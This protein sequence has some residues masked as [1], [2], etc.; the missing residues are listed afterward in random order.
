MPERE[1]S[2]Y[3]RLQDWPRDRLEAGLAACTEHHVREAIHKA[4]TGRKLTEDDFL[5]LLSPAAESCLEIMAQVAAAVTLRHFGRTVQLFT[6]LYLANFCTNRCVY[7][8]FNTTNA[9]PRSSLT[10]EDIEREGRAIA[11]TGL[12]HIL[13]L[14]GDARRKTG[15]DYIAAAARILR[16]LFAGIGVEVYSMHEEEYGLLREAGVDSL[17]VF[18]ETYNETL[19]AEVHPAG[20][21]RDFRFRLDALHRGGKAGFRALNAGGLLGLDDWRCE[22]FFTGL[23]A[24]WLQHRHPAVE[25]AISVPRMRPHA[26]SPFAVKPVSERD[27]VHIIMAHRLFLPMAGIT[28]S[29]R[30]RAALRDHLLGLGVTTVSAGVSTSVGGHC[31][32]TDDDTPQFDIADGR[33]VDEMAAAI[34]RQGLQPVF[35]NWEPI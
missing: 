1:D 35:K 19:Y 32:P 7:C 9:I 21:K 26:G 28:V 14:T 24:A 15:P 29:S 11:A 23:H 5:A 6:P 30:E 3:P 16:P 17:T 33:S 34:R 13:L 27:L 25:V 12:R 2:F 8:G 22:S 4:E 18:Q 20:P 10:P 31:A